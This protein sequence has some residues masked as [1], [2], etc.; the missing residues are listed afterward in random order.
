MTLAAAAVA[1][2][3]NAQNPK[4]GISGMVKDSI[5]NTP[6]SFVTIRLVRPGTGKAIAVAT[7]DENGRFN[8]G[9]ATASGKYTL[10]VVCIGKQT[11]RNESMLGQATVTAERRLV[12]AEI[13]RVSY[14]M[15]E[16]PEA[17]TNSLLD[18]LRKVPMVTVDG[19]D[20]I[21]VNGSSGFK[22]YVNG[23][24]SQMMSSNP[25][26]ILKNYPASAIKRV[27]VITDPG[28]K[29]DAEGT[30]GILN[31]VTDAETRTH[32]LAQREHQ[33][34]RCVWQSFRHDANRQTHALAQ[35][36][37]GQQQTATQ[38]DDF[39]T[40]SLQRCRQPSFALQRRS[41]RTRRLQIRKHRRQL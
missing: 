7:S 12:K 24:P 18:M 39:G 5:T 40:R 25:S 28:A 1:T 30:S 11:L 20:N 33:Q 3:A 16:D 36:R 17:Q 38:P 21:K 32:L 8:I 4:T 9:R 19:E 13:D 34:S 29:Y 27:E 22:V 41:L 2:A 14:S 23:K 31:I 35:F 37:H 6:E 10:E 15:K 26:L